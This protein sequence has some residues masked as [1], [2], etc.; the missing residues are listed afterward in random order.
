MIQYNYNDLESISEGS[1]I[2]CGKANTLSEAL[3]D[4]QVIHNQIVQQIHHPE[5]G[6]YRVARPP[7][8]FTASPVPFGGHAPLL[9]ADTLE[10]M[11]M[12]NAKAAA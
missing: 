8:V 10:V 2:L 6:P 5:L 7:V 1:G 12:L 3:E 4:P 11:V 9:G